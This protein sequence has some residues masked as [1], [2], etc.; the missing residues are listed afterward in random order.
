MN[1]IELRGHSSYEQ[2]KIQLQNTIV[3]GTYQA[4]ADIEDDPDVVFASVSVN[5]VSLAGGIYEQNQSY[6]V[7]KT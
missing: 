1:P 6:P 7:D 2:P 3:F 4:E 5:D